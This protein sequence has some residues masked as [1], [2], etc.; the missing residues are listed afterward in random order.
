MEIYLDQRRIKPTGV[1]T[2]LGQIVED[3]RTEAAKD[4]RVIVGIRCDGADITHDDLAA[5]LAEPAE[6]YAR[7]DLQSGRAEQLVVDALHQALQV[8]D[9][10]DQQRA[11]VV[12]WLAQGEAARA[13]Q[14]LAECF[15]Q[16]TQIHQ[17]IAQSMAFLNLDEKE[18]LVE[19]RPLGS[20]LTDICGQLQQ[21]KE[22]LEV[23]D[24]VLLGDL[25][26]YEF[27]AAVGQWRV[28]V[29]AV[30]ARAQNAAAD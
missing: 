11:Q 8:L 10:S 19:E 30:L 26:Q 23:G 24:D 25:L 22:V 5:R 14:A 18:L 1:A 13:R 12:E 27:D 20:V 29:Q 3:A 2:T 15:Q 9:D 17:A 7:V 21:V 28:M 16:W 6:K 4:D